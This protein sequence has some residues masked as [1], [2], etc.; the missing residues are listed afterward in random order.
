MR[1]VRE[2]FEA[3]QPLVSSTVNKELLKVAY[4]VSSRRIRDLDEL[5][6]DPTAFG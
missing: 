5:I 6:D 4:E 3:G 2:A 1:E